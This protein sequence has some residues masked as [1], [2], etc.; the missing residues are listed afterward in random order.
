M[1]HAYSV[2]KP[3]FKGSRDGLLVVTSNTWRSAS[4]WK[5]LFS[6]TIHLPVL[7]TAHDRLLTLSTL[8]AVKRVHD[9]EL[10]VLEFIKL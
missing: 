9:V 4:N 1:L 2:T 8:G 5:E 6:C 3:V 10:S 7:S